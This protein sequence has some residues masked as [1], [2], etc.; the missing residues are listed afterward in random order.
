MASVHVER[1]FSA[2]VERVFEYLS[3]H[4]NLG[5]L[6]APARVERLR[7]GDTERN[8]VGSI[9]RLSFGGLI[10]FEETITAVVPNERIE[11]RITRGSPMRNHYGVMQFSGLPSGGSHLD[12]RI[13]LEARVPGL[14]GVV[15]ATLNRSIGRG[16]DQVEARL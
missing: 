2:P 5:V 11:Y 10:P 1:D 8:G 9:R 13:G 12:Y 6:F 14:A 15:A 7:H 16:L 4:E 3:E